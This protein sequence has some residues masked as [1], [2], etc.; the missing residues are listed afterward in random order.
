MRKSRYAGTCPQA[1]KAF[2]LSLPFASSDKCLLNRDL[3][4][5]YLPRFVRPLLSPHLR[6]SWIR[7]PPSSC[8][9]C[10]SSLIPIVLARIN[11]CV[12]YPKS[13]SFSLFFSLCWRIVSSY[14][15]FQSS[16]VK[17]PLRIARAMAAVV[18]SWHDLY[19][20]LGFLKPNDSEETRTF[21][22]T[23][24]ISEH[25]V[26]VSEAYY[27]RIQLNIHRSATRIPHFMDVWRRLA[28]VLPQSA[29]ANLSVDVVQ[30]SIP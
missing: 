16:F 22:I 9:F 7:Y 15:A 4:P 23:D 25:P 2:S 3:P 17:T 24:F 30:T 19:T 26:F 5:P 27:F 10:L 12:R 28:T 6:I 21:I 13:P 20:M 1:H 14:H 11:E 29:L 8:L 18:R